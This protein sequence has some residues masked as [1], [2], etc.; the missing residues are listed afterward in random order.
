M[1]CGIILLLITLKIWEVRKSKLNFVITSIALLNSVSYFLTLDPLVCFKVK[2]KSLK[3]YLQQ[4]SLEKKNM[5][6]TFMFKSSNLPWRPRVCLLNIFIRDC[7]LKIWIGLFN[8]ETWNYSLGTK[9]RLIL[10]E[11]SCITLK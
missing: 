8:L 6:R 9:N 11:S 2:V 7:A 10:P 5:I 4:S 1:N 3:I